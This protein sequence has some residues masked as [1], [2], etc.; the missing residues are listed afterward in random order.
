M[1]VQFIRRTA[2]AARPMPLSM[3]YANGGAAFAHSSAKEKNLE[4][5]KRGKNGC[6]LA[7]TRTTLAIWMDDAEAHSY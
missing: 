6:F 1:A 5:R 3:G 7:P 2:P 4:T